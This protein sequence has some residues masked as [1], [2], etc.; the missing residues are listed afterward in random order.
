MDVFECIESRRSVRNYLDVPVEWEKIGKIVEAAK[1][2]PSSGN[3]QNWVFI[4]VKD[5]DSRKTLADSSLQQ[6]W[7]EKAPVHIVV[8]ADTKKAE[9]YYGMRGERLYSVQNCAAAVENMLLAATALGLGSCWIGA[10]DE[11]IVKRTVNIPE[12]WRPQ[13][14]VTIGYYKDKVPMPF[15]NELYTITYIE[16]FW[17]RIIDINKVMGF[18]SAKVQK[19]VGTIKDQF[20]KKD[21]HIEKAK[22]GA[23]KA[24]EKSKNILNKL[25]KKN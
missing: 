6:Q 25:K 9:M 10:F 21:K 8:C 23:K 12:G 5:P 15:K 2:A 13:A 17:S 7:M 14:I 19:V 16:G 18:P 11:E 1:Y 22:Q 24:V 20:D 4:I 3:L